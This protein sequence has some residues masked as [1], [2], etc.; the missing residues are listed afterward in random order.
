MSRFSRGVRRR[1]EVGDARRQV[2]ASAARH[3]SV[4]PR[5]ADEAVERMIDDAITDPEPAEGKVKNAYWCGECQRYTVTIDRHKGVTPMFLAC[6]AA[7]VGP[8][9][10]DNPCRGMSQSMMYPDEPWP[11]DHPDL[12]AGPTWEW[13]APDAAELKRLRKKDA[14]SFEH[15]MKGG[16]LLRKVEAA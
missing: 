1:A 12:T 3:Q 15:V 4:K 7:G 5:T 8:G 16:L 9:H 6:R 13:Y 10:P 11:I 2:K 14:E